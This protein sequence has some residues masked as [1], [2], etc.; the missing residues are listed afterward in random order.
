MAN[1]IT[2]AGLEVDT[3]EELITKLETDF[4]TIYGDDINLSSNSPD[5]QILNIFAEVVT[6][7]LE[8]LADVYNSFSP[9]N[10]NGV[11][12]DQR[13]ALNGISRQGG[14]YTFQDVL[15]TVDRAL[16]LQGLDDSLYVLDGSGFTIKDD[17]G[18]RYI[19]AATT[20]FSAAGA[21]T[22]AFRAAVLGKVEPAVNTIDTIETVTLGVVSVN[23]PTA[24]TYVGVDEESDMAMKLRRAKS[25]RLA[26]TGPSD[27]LYSAINEISGV[28]DCLVKENDTGSTAAGIAAHS[29]WVIVEGGAD[30]DIGAAVYAKK[31]PGCGQTGD[32]TV[33][34]ERPDGSA[35]TAKF[36]RP[37]TEDL[38]IRFTITP[39]RSGIAF[40]TDQ[41]KA[42][43]VTALS[44]KL[45]QSP[46]IS[47]VIV[48]MLTIEPDGVLSV[49]GV[50]SNGTD[51][52]EIIDPTDYQH[53]FTLSTAH[54]TVTV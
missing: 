19:L 32:E 12:L 52:D 6:D 29:I 37:V 50:S 31:I 42:D 45:G 53:K 2:D 23:N 47:D 15:V 40:D 51:W 26:S 54:I 38:H 49:V 25:F 18:N 39:K 41:I 30:A 7:I 11:L 13:V 22:L 8:L 44:F 36:D 20:A 9:D 46:N 33:A 24:V 17:A 48:A 3:L 16:T 5:A 28:T 21:Q 1:Q 27:S 14:T 34:V 43:L 4:K 35:F 10:A